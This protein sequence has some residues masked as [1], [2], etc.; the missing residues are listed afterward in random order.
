MRVALAL[1]SALLL[2]GCIAKTALDIVTLP[3]RAVSAGVDVPHH[4]QSEA[5]QARGAPAARGRRARGR[6]AREPSGAGNASARPTDPNW[7]WAVV[8]ARL[9][10]LGCGV[11]NSVPLE[12]SR[13]LEPE[14]P[15]KGE[16]A[17]TDPRR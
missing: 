10:P 5:D 3:V 17:P 16:T 9:L 4:Q 7:H 12:E 1:A 6:E 13:M 11:T 14:K 2:S 8:Q 15:E